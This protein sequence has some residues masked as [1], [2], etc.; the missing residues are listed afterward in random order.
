MKLVTPDAADAAHVSALTASSRSGHLLML[1]T[2]VEHTHAYATAPMILRRTEG[3]GEVEQICI[4]TYVH[5]LICIYA[6]PDNNN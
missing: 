4:Y 5:I 3:E 1:D 6:H 2:W